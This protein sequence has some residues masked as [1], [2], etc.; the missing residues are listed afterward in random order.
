MLEIVAAVVVLAS[1][2]PTGFDPL[3]K[4]SAASVEDRKALADAIK[5]ASRCGEKGRPSVADFDAVTVGWGWKPAHLYILPLELETALRK[6]DEANPTARLGG[7]PLDFHG[8]GANLMLCINGMYLL[9]QEALCEHVSGL[10][11]KKVE[12]ATF[13]AVVVD[14]L[15][16][17][18]TE[19]ERKEFVAKLVTAQKCVRAAAKETGY[20]LVS[21]EEDCRRVIVKTHGISSE[22][23]RILDRLAAVKKE[24]KEAFEKHL[25]AA[26]A[27]PKK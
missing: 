6:H 19:Q 13:A 20:C 2:P 12:T 9:T 26:A 7:P 1:M 4:V 27:P 25:T 5:K 24:Y 17:L 11:G 8:V 14:H 16:G 10:V 21:D 18:K 22:P 3:E 23:E 15:K